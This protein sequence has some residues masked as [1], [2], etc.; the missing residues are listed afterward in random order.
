[1]GTDHHLVID[2]IKIRLARLVRRKVGRIPYNTKKFREGDLRD[3]FAIKL[4]NRF[5]SLYRKDTSEDSGADQDPAEI[6]LKSIGVRS[7]VPTSIYSV[8]TCDGVRSKVPI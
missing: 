5:E 2:Q 6:E 7:K 4:Q 1:M 8:D 3:T